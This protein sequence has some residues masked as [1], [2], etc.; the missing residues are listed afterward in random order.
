[1]QNGQ[2]A[3]VNHPARERAEQTTEDGHESWDRPREPTLEAASNGARVAP[4]GQTPG[5]VLVFDNQSTTARLAIRPRPLLRLAPDPRVARPGLLTDIPRSRRDITRSRE[6]PKRV[7]R[8]IGDGAA[9]GPRRT[10]AG[11]RDRPA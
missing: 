4:G 2:C 1:V 7:P 11:R 5:R 8:T 10:R 6:G 3:I 9:S